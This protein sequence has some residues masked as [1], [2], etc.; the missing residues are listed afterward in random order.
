VVPVDIA[1]V[2]RGDLTLVQ[3]MSG[4]VRIHRDR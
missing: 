3:G 1:I 4:T 2:D